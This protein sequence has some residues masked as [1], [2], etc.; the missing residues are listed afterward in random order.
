MALNPDILIWAR[1]KAGL[2]RA[3]AARSL[4]FADSRRWTAD[5]RLE[6][7]EKGQVRPSR[8]VL[9]EMEKKY[10][11]PMLVFYLARPPESQGEDEVFRT[12]LGAPS[13]HDNPR[14]DALIR[15][16]R[17][18]QQI[19][20]DLL[21]DERVEPLD[22][23]G[24][25]TI[26][27]SSEWLSADI[28]QRTGFSLEDYREKSNSHRAFAY[29][30]TRLEESGIFVLLMSNLGSHHTSIAV[31]VF[32]GF[33]LVDPLAPFVVLN[34]Q[35]AKTA[36]SFTALHEAVH[37][38]IGEPGFMSGTP[39]DSVETLANDVAGELFLPRREIAKLSNKQVTGI[40]TDLDVIEKF[41]SERNI[42]KQMVAYRL[43]RVARID[44]TIWR[45]MD[46]KLQRIA[47]N[48][49]QQIVAKGNGPNYYVV[50]R[51][52]LGPSLVNLTQRSLADKV[53]TYTRAARVLGVQ[54][55]SVEPLL[56]THSS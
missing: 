45:A 39:A 55:G 25:A 38:W 21:E 13:A 24:S 3:D 2:S 12:I 40:A 37:L 41:A 4:G 51:Y 43:F 52:R 42:S 54:P 20:R 16:V 50:Q 8:S 44:R 18:K 47:P 30:R 29:V 46:A 7:M 56:R 11:V 36:L 27:S 9:Q 28:M 49:P 10:R 53:I 15:Q 17:V 26:D 5:G 35:D 34:D 1:E 32:R 19:V 14:L 31:A 23:V 6:A 22:F 48:V 33:A